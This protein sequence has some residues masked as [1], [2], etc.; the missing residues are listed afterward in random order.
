MRL[1]KQRGTPE[2]GFNM[3]PMIDIVFLLIIF[4]MT[5]SQI[6]RVVDHP[7]DLPEIENGGTVTDPIA[8]TVNV[9]RQGKLIVAEKEFEMG[10]LLV[11]VNQQLAKVKNDPD[12]LRVRIRGD[13]QCDMKTIN[14]LIL[15]LERLNISQVRI[16]IRGKN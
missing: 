9:D 12:Q 14:Q 15:E 10:E 4:F 3:T 1:S 8:M 2:S 11:F 13:R 5:V 7:V 16:A 6:T